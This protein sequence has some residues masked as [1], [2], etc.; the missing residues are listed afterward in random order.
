MFFVLGEEI[1]SE[2]VI[3]SKSSVFGEAEGDL[4]LW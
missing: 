4:L 2:E 1:A 3:V